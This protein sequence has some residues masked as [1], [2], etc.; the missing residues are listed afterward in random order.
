MLSLLAT[1]GG[2]LDFDSDIK[3]RYY[4]VFTRSRHRNWMIRLLNPYYQHVY[5]VKKSEGEQFWIVINPLSSHTDIKMLP[6]SEY[7]H[8]RMMTN[9]EDI[10]LTVD[11]D[12]KKRDRHTLCIINCV[13]IVKSLLG[14][15]AFWV[16]TPYQLYKCIVRE[17]GRFYR[18]KST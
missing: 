7:P 10:V 14:I 11:T 9:E 1:R 3:E 8:I 5:A 12:I 6:V 15:R 13:E 17:H 18:R 4:V 16:F 2:D